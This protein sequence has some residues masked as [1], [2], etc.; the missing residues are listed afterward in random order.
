MGVNA[1]PTRKGVQ[2]SRCIPHRNPASQ[3]SEA[4][5]R[6]VGVSAHAP[7]QSISDPVREHAL[8]VRLHQF[9]R[10][11]LRQGLPPRL[12]YRSIAANVSSSNARTTARYA[13]K[14]P[15]N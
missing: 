15:R 12:P 14:E 2:A 4:R 11:R 8:I 13:S 7:V 6:R 3:Y 9:L 10:G 1:T 5:L